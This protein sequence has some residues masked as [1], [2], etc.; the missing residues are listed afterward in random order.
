MQF[1]ACAVVRRFAPL[2]E[3]RLSHGDHDV[4]VSGPEN[5]QAGLSTHPSCCVH[6]PQHINSH[7][8]VSCFKVEAPFAT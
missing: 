5:G 3:Q 7:V 8:P 4:L 1:V 6:P 2:A